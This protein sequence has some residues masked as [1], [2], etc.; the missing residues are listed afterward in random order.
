MRDLIKEY[1]NKLFNTLDNRKLS[2]EIEI[3]YNSILLAW[4]NKKQIFICGNGGSAGN[5]IHIANDYLYGAGVKNK[6]GL[7]VEALSSNQAVITCLA[8]DLGYE[9]I[10]SEQLK[11]KA[12]KNDILIILSGSGNSKNVI[13]AIKIGNKIGMKTFAMV[14]FDGGK[15]LKLAKNKVYFKINDMQISEDLQLI[16]MHMIMKKLSKIKLNEKK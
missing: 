1:K 13:N 6:K 5:A 8:N 16:V 15:C 11:V 2:S 12:N 14:G 3:L 7:K 4:K 9:H 10:Y